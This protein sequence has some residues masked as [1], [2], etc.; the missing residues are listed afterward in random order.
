MKLVLLCLLLLVLGCGCGPKEFDAPHSPD[1]APSPLSGPLVDEGPRPA[2]HKPSMTQAPAQLQGPLSAYVARM[3]GLALEDGRELVVYVGATWCEPCGHFHDALE[4]GALD[5]AFPNISFLEFDF[6][7]H[8]VGLKEAGYA[9]R[10]VPL[11]ALPNAD[12]KASE[13]LHQGAIKGPRAVDFLKPKI[14][15]ILG[16]GAAQP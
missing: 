15:A 9:K 2:L 12:G 7:V 14:R 13:H 16:K 3:R 8:Q 4:A 11:F 6:D 10:F 1:S 5:A